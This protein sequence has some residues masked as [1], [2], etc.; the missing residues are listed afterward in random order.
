ME[1]HESDS[2]FTQ[3]TEDAI[4]LGNLPLPDASSFV[5]DS[6]ELGHP[7]AHEGVLKEIELSGRPDDSN[8]HT[9]DWRQMD[10]TVDNS[11]RSVAINGE[12]LALADEEQQDN[13]SHLPNCTQSSAGEIGTM[14]DKAS[15]KLPTCDIDKSRKARNHRN[16]PV[17]EVQLAAD[18]D[19]NELT[20]S[21][22]Q[23]WLQRNGEDNL[24]VGSKEDGDSN[25]ARSVSLSF[26]CN[27]RPQCDSPA[28]DTRSSP[29]LEPPSV[30]IINSR[31][32]LLEST[33]SDLAP[34]KSFKRHRRSEVSCENNSDDNDDPSDSDY[35]HD[36]GDDPRESPTIRRRTK[37]VR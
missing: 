10:P 35:V 4:G 28:R 37:R 18:H 31:S 1:H 8:M 9:I 20:A 17:T 5:L 13:Q 7:R 3:D 27:E 24:P 6:D 26:Q 30:V 23:D 19:V 22:Q 29:A 34:R 32:Q 16:Q 11:N 12:D 36:R 14:S 2:K 33:N 25:T 15:S 21:S